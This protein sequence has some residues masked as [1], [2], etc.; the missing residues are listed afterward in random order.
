M[1][2]GM[3]RRPIGLLGLAVGFAAFLL[4]A[5]SL[6]VWSAGRD[7][8]YAELENVPE[9]E[10]ALVLGCPPLTAQGDRNLYFE[11]RMDAAAELYLADKVDRILVSGD[12]RTPNY[13]EPLAM[14]K[15]LVER[16]VT[17]ADI[18]ADEAGLRTLDSVVR[19]RAVF[20]A[21][22]VTI[23]SQE[24]HNRRAI[25]L[26]DRFGVD[27]VGYNAADVD[28]RPWSPLSLREAA[29]R[30]RAFADALRWRGRDPRYDVGPVHGDATGADVR[31]DGRSAAGFGT[32]LSGTLSRRIVEPPARRSAG[33]LAHAHGA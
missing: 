30:I 19:A 29:A 33:S 24:F 15:A 18:V 26:A 7:R 9:R 8:L 3:S 21:D 16:G 2:R 10:V 20:G 6:R 17:D 22:R 28:R 4:L 25:Y 13:N 11:H 27:A 1:A 12:H 14:R 23:V 32:S 31:R 5:V